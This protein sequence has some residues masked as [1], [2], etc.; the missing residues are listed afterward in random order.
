MT[1]KIIALIIATSLM[2]G[3]MVSFAGA[4]AGELKISGSTTVQPVAQELATTLMAKNPGLNIA[5]A[6]GGSG[7]GIKDVA[8]GRVNIGMASRDLKADE[9]SKGLI[10]S[11]I[12]MDAL[13]LVVHPENKVRELQVDQIAKIYSGEITNWN[14]VGGKNAP[15]HANGRTAASGTYDFF[16][17]HVMKGKT[18]A[19]TVN[20]YESQGL[21]KQSVVGDVNAIG[22]VS[23]AIVDKKVKPL[24]VAGQKP[25][26]QTAR[27]GKYPLVRT[28]NLVTKGAPEGLAK[29]FIDYALSKDGQKIVAKHYL[30]LKDEV[31]K[32]QVKKVKKKVK[33][34][35]KKKK[36]NSKKK[37]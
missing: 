10:P 26:L 36:K 8:A 29:D 32:K 12:A 4:L 35:G 31:V 20:Q 22:Y 19:P 9:I 16:M 18:L 23:L 1:R 34:Y 5:I 17:E 14:Q 25:T 24:A 11:V 13:I 33:K 3:T 37:K 6:A 27:S 7:V 2:L 15:I 28:L 30:S 21:V